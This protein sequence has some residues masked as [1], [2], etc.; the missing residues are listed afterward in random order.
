M[1]KLG[2]ALTL[3]LL[4]ACQKP[5]VWTA[6][7]PLESE[8]PGGLRVRG[9]A[10][11]NRLDTH[12]TG[13]WNVRWTVNG[14]PLDRLW[15]FAG[16]PAGQPLVKVRGEVPKGAAVF[17]EGM[18]AEDVAELFESFLSAGGSTF[19]RDR[20][21][22]HPFAGGDGFRFDYTLIR[23]ADDVTLKGAAFG[24]VRGG[25]LYLIVF[26]APRIHYFAALLPRA[27][28]VVKSARIEP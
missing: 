5:A 25:R 9:E 27:E 14:D 21:A 6:V 3:L 1:K 13:T 4:A 10:G 16:V 11:W 28:A 19:H 7:T 23:K 18:Q 17:K 26:Q 12:P 22:P 24:A 2:A 8:L 20:L 15:F